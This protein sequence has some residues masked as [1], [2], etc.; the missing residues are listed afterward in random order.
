LDQTS[1]SQN[2]LERHDF[3][4]P[5]DTVTKCFG[6]GTASAVPLLAHPDGL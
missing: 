4:R 6:K 2:F 5:T 1:L 3:A